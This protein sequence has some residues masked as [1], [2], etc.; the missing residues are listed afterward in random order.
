[1]RVPWGHCSDPSLFRS[2]C[3]AD[4][5]LDQFGSPKW[6]G[7]PWSVLVAVVGSPL[8]KRVLPAVGGLELVAVGV[9]A[10]VCLVK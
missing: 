8:K 5:Q 9:R 4:F 1:M 6:L 3:S 2:T 7:S 10:A